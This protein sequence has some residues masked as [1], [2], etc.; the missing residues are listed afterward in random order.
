VGRQ[1]HTPI[2]FC[3]DPQRPVQKVAL[4]SGSGASL[5]R[6]AQ[7]KGADVLVTGDVKH[8]DATDAELL[9]IALVDAGHY[10]TEIIMVAAVAEQ[11]RTVMAQ[12]GLAVEVLQHTG[13]QPL[14]QETE[15]D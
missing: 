14:F 4:C 11:L 6:E 1:L 2:R 8:H 7:F 15:R 12:R 13:E 3:G 10:G 9:G 5:L